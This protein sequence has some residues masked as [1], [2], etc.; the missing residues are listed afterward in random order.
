MSSTPE[1]HD[2]WKD[3]VVSMLAV[4]NFSLEKAWLIADGLERES[5]IDPDDLRRWD[6]E[7]IAFRL[8]RA[9]YKRGAHMTP[10]AAKRLSALGAFVQDFSRSACEEL[11]VTG[12]RESI[13]SVLEKVVGIGPTVLR[14]FFLLQGR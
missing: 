1:L 6:L 11:F 8:E 10:L 14:N 2:I 9:G 3:L 12:D 4:N 5:L 13:S 7:E